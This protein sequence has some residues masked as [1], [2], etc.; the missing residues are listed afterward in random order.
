MKKVVLS[1]LLL[2]GMQAVMAQSKLG[3]KLSPTLALTRVDY[4]DSNFDVDADGS[5]G[6]FVFGLIYDYMLT[7]NY[8]FST[9]LLYAPKRVGFSAREAGTNAPKS[10]AYN[11]QYLQL[12]AT[13][14]LFTNELALDTRV[15]FQ[16][17]ALTEIKVAEK[18]Q[19]RDFDI[20]EDFKFFD[21]SLYVG[22]GIERRL[23]YNTI[24]F[25]GIFYNRGLTNIVSD[26]QDPYDFDIH[27]DLIGLDLGVKF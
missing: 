15:Y 19:N 10:E 12:P 18:P 7:E 1:L 3:L 20:V 11:L 2:C 25:G 14:K 21:F 4:E 9:G 27:T 5:G 16:L 24:V 26:L 8:Y 22:S 6:R 17:G 13:I 23:G